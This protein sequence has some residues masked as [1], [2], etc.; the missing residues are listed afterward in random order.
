MLVFMAGTARADLYRWIDPDSGSVKLS[1][2]PPSDPRVR[3]EVIRYGGPVPAKPA[4]PDAAVTSLETRWREMAATITG[5]TAQD[6]AGGGAKLRQYFEA[7]EALRVELDRQDPGG[8][9]R[10][11]AESASVLERLRAGL[12]AQP[13]VKPPPQ[14]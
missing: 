7:Y 8:A 12:G 10:R 14:K 9:A 2:M 13:G 5:L 4:A 1:S 6:L 3:A 11:R